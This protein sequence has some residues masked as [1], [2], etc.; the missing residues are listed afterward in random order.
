MKITL[1]VVSS[2]SNY[3]SKYTNELLSYSIREIS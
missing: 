2:S 1:E 3:I